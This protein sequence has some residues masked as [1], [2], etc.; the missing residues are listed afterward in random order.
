MAIE[1]L[2]SADAFDTARANELARYPT[3]EKGI[4]RLFP[5]P[6]PRGTPSYA[7][8]ADATVFTLG[9]CFAREVDKALTRAGFHVVS[10][11]AELDAEVQRPGKDESLYNKY[12]VHSILNELRWALDPATPYPGAAALVEVSPGRW[13][14][15]QLGGSA[16]S[17]SLDEMLVL[18]AAYGRVM[19]RAAEADVVVLT[20]G[21]VEAWFDTQTGL[22]LNAAPPPR[23]AARQPE[24]FQLRVLDGAEVLEALEQ[25]HALL[26]RHGKPGVRLL[27]T[28]SPV[29][30]LMTFRAQDVLVANTYS[31]AVQRAAIEQF[32]AQ[33]D[34]VDYFPSYEFVTLGDPAT[35][36]HRDFRHVH[37]DVVARIMT[38]VMLEYTGGPQLEQAAVLA[39]LAALYKA[40]DYEGVLEM[41]AV[42]KTSELPLDTLYRVGLA[43]KKQQH[44]AQAL[45]CFEQCVARDPRHTAAAENAE[46][47]A[48]K[49]GRRAAPA[50]A[51][52]AA[53]ASAAPSTPSAANPAPIVDG[54][55][56][57]PRPG[58]PVTAR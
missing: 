19:A 7:I 3:P 18:R 1:I 32:V 56:A 54:P 35:Q 21:L 38:S 4:E 13:A 57:V 39:E 28:V 25:I 49:L 24:R 46:R 23:T 40:G 31:K 2:S 29:P 51:A 34:N 20:L 50:P 15:L 55:D 22:Y 53:P 6:T 10:R 42:L 12:T 30:L 44:W 43:H 45:A 58:A 52:A 47:M 14:D 11:S 9:S 27:V 5:F 41:A 36:W 8:A 37:P 33:H 26:Q 17:G 16:F 48:Q